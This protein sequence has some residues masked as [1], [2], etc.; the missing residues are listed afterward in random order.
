MQEAVIYLHGFLFM[1]TAG[2]TLA[3]DDHVRVD[4]FYSRLTQT[5]KH[6][7][8][9]VGCILFLFPLCWFVFTYSLNYVLLSWRV[10]ESSPESGGLPYLFLLKSLLLAMPV[11]LG[12]QGIHLLLSS[13]S[14]LTQDKS[15]A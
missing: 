8:N 5:Q 10:M 3:K 1:L 11:L 2:Y 6:W 15:N 12:L 13:I 9:L 7:V 14:G 4:V